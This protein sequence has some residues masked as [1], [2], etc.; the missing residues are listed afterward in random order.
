[1]KSSEF[2]IEEQ[3]QVETQQLENEHGNIDL[4]YPWLARWLWHCM[5]GVLVS[6]FGGAKG[7][8]TL[9]SRMPCNGKRVSDD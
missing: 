4:A 6:L 8:R 7:S 9:A 1:M 2:F 5:P 3:S